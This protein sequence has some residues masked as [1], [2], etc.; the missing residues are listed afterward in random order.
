MSDDAK[1]LE[2]W[3]PVIADAATLAEVVDQAFHYRGDVTLVLDDGREVRGYLFNR[4]GEAPEP[5]V[6]MFEPGVDAP[7][8]IPYARIRAIQFTGRDTAAGKSYAA[9][10]QQRQAAKAATGA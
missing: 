5:F 2:G 8:T 1:G 4:D 3:A 9:W 6:Q 7:S 10:L